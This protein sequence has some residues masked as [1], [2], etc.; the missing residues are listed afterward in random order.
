MSSTRSTAHRPRVGRRI[1][2]TRSG[3]SAPS[4]SRPTARASPRLAGSS[5]GPDQAIAGRFSPRYPSAM[6]SIGSIV[7][8]VD[9]LERQKAFWSAALDYVPRGPEGGDDEGF[10][11]LRPRDGIGPNVSLD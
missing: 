1:G 2:S 7:I 3:R 5:T 9:D 4:G 6:V 10:A 8:R 11:L